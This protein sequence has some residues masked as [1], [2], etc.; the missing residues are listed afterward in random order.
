MNSL[1]NITQKKTPFELLH[2]GTPSYPTWE[3]L[4]IKLLYMT[5]NYLKKNSVPDLLPIGKK[6]WQFYDLENKKFIISRDMIFNKTKVVYTSDLH[7]P[8]NSG[9]F[10]T[11]Y[12]FGKTYVDS[13]DMTAK[14]IE[15]STR[16]V[17]QS[18]T[19]NKSSN[20]H[21]FGPCTASEFIPEEATITHGPFT[22]GPTA[23]TSP[24]DASSPYTW[25]PDVF[26][27]PSTRHDFGCS[28]PNFP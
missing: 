7:N 27:A 23:M 14:R 9:D 4:V 10:A 13:P 5:M 28:S 19:E 16:A 3:V 21:L 15:S 2:G 18:T 17:Y 20:P 26:S 12:N 25:V 8:S 1:S 24:Q 6:G 22:I 11:L